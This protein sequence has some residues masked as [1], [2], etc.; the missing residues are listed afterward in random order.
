MR[1]ST[2][3]TDNFNERPLTEGGKR[4]GVGSFGTVFYGILH[5][6]SGQK[7]DVAVKRLKNVTMATNHFKS[8][9]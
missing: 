2:G 7:Y 1:V 6:E 4:L 8:L 9:V 3:T 5:S